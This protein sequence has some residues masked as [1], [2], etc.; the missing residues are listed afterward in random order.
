M[1]Y[2]YV[3]KSIHSDYT[4][5]WMTND[6]ERR[7]KEHNSWKTPSN[8]KYAPFELIYSEV[9]E[10]SKI[11]REREKYLKWWNWRNRLKNELKIL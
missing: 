9:V 3:I 4:Y 11:A 1:Y 7:I 8:K 10:N 2:V 6:I 5:T